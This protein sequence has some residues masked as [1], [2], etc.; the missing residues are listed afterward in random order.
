MTDQIKAFWDLRCV[1]ERWACRPRSIS[2]IWFQWMSWTI[3]AKKN[4]HIRFTKTSWQC[5]C[6]CLCLLE[7]CYA[8]LDGLRQVR[9]GLG[10]RLARS[11]GEA[12]QGLVGGV[13]HRCQGGG[14][15]V[16]QRLDSTWTI[17]L[18][19]CVRHKLAFSGGFTH[20]GGK[21]Q[22]PLMIKMPFSCKRL[23]IY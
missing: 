15:R 23:S 11:V 5:T 8:L 21:W 18:V 20:V 17:L 19:F 4:T 9:L 16:G 6:V 14:H 13:G 7:N 3:S 10:R 2:L 12:G 1:G 22:R